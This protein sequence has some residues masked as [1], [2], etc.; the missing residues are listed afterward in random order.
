MQKSRFDYRWA[1]LLSHRDAYFARLN[2][3]PAKRA[4]S[5]VVGRPAASGCTPLER[6]RVPRKPRLSASR[7]RVASEQGCRSRSAW[8][9][10]PRAADRPSRRPG[11]I[12]FADQTQARQLSARHRAGVLGAVAALVSLSYGEELG[13]C[14]ARKRQP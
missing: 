8:R 3:R 2:E 12:R 14:P 1:H 5:V 13:R 10:T 9:S 7:G 4:D 6:S 11:R